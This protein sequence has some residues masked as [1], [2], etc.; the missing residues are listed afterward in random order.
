MINELIGWF[1]IAENWQQVPLRV[2]QHAGYTV[3]ALV[4]SAVIAIPLGMYV[5]HTGRGGVV[6]VGLSNV[7]RSLPTLGL[8]TFLFL[9]LAG[10]AGPATYI[11]LVV[12]AIPPILAGTY[13]GVSEADGVVVDAATGMGMTGRQRLFQVE[14]PIALPLLLGGIRNATLQIVATAAVG[15]Y[16]G[17][18]GLGRFVLDGLSIYDYGEVAA[19]AILTALLAIVFDLLLAGLGRLVVPRGLRL[20]LAA[21]GEAAKGGAH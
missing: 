17:L 6:L 4:I 11:A 12:L 21:T 8:I 1:S 16:V 15:A 20:R 3:V 10:L 13:A 19:G 5:G 18:G 2:G 9:L 7:I 14:V